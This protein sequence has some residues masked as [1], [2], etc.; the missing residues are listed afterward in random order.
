MELGALDGV[1]YLAAPAGPGMAQ[2]TVD[3][4]ECTLIFGTTDIIV[5]LKWILHDGI[6]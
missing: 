6:A 2:L 4:T 3:S 1:I 5:P